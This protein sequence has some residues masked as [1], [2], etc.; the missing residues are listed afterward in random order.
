M[1]QIHETQ[2]CKGTQNIQDKV[3]EFLPHFKLV[4]VKHSKKAIDN[5]DITAF[6][7]GITNTLGPL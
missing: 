6:A 3:V 1:K 7:D 2:T 5:V 4:L